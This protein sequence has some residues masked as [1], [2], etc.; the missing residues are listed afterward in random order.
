MVAQV[1]VNGLLQKSKAAEMLNGSLLPRQAM[2]GGSC[3][4]KPASLLQLNEATTAVVLDAEGGEVIAVAA[5]LRYSP[6]QAYCLLAEVDERL[7]RKAGHV[8]SLNSVWRDVAGGEHLG[9]KFVQEQANE[10]DRDKQPLFIQAHIRPTER[11]PLEHIVDAVTERALGVKNLELKKNITIDLY[12]GEYD[13]SM[14]RDRIGFCVTDKN[15]YLEL[16]VPTDAIRKQLAGVDV[17]EVKVRP[18]NA[19]NMQ[20]MFDYDQAVSQLNRGEYLSFLTSLKGITGA[21]AYDANDQPIG[22]ALALGSNMLQCYAESQTAAGALVLQLSNAV[23]QSMML[24]T[25]SDSLLGVQLAPV[26][27]KRRTV[28]RFHT[29]AVPSQVKWDKVFV[30]NIGT[31][32]L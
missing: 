21:V 7:Q 15:E 11:Y 20:Q 2:N 26:A 17:S 1:D 30:L 27:T 10:S 16:T 8:E 25:A 31:H 9:F 6:T 29:R 24:N 28:Y 13:L 5:V 14:W 19:D 12:D 3:N 23:G 32:L 18:L 22:Y 4:D